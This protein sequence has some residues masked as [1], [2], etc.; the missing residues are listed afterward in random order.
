MSSN[1]MLNSY[2][3]LVTGSMCVKLPDFLSHCNKSG[4]RPGL[5]VLI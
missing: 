1:E 5:L 2:I 4:S 3:K